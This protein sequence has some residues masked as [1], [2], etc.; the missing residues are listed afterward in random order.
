MRGLGRN[1]EELG[2]PGYV[3]EPVMLPDAPAP[4]KSKMLSSDE[5]FKLPGEL[6]FF[7]KPHAQ[8]N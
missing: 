6:S 7:K 1:A 2:L 5:T 3:W 4:S 8:L